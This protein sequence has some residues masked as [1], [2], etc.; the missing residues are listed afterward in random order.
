MQSH[1]IITGGKT[2][3]FICV[4]ALHFF[5]NTE[6]SNFFFLFL[7]PIVFA[8]VKSHLEIVLPSHCLFG[9][10]PWE[11][12]SAEFSFPSKKFPGGT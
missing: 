3:N 10:G 8:S 9:N 12:S 7:C 4:F 6:I 5:L 11:I 2:L 1:T